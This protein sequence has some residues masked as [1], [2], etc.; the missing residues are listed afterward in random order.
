MSSYIFTC[1]WDHFVWVSP[2]S[3][4]SCLVRGSSLW[5]PSLQLPRVQHD[6][7][8]HQPHW[9]FWPLRPQQ[10]VPIHQQKTQQRQSIWRA[11]VG[12]VTVRLQNNLYTGNYTELK[13]YGGVDGRR[14]FQMVCHWSD[15]LKSLLILVE[16]LW[17]WAKHCSPV[18]IS[19]LP[20]HYSLTCINSRSHSAW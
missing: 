15:Q 13:G 5:I 10:Y 2:L 4:V 3:A 11:W 18:V 8:Q 20:L 12:Q 17:H 16:L 9:P 14:V 19:L 7:S 6:Q 1:P